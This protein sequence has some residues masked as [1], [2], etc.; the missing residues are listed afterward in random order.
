MD[1][2][3][4]LRDR[5]TAGT[6]RRP[7]VRLPA[8]LAQPSVLYPLL[9]VLAWIA[10]LAIARAVGV[11]LYNRDPLIRIGA[12]PVVGQ[13]DVRLSALVLPA[14][15]V[16]AFAVAY[17][18]VPA[19]RL[20]FRWLLAG[21]WLA[22]AGWAVS[23]ALVDGP[24]ALPA[25]LQ[26]RYEY[27]N[28]VPLVTS[29][30]DFLATFTDRIDGYSTHT[31]GHPPLMVLVFWAM[32]RIGL[33]G[34]I[35]ATVLVIG[36][37]AVAAPAVLVAAR[38]VAGEAQA[39]R[40]APFVVFAPL[41]VWVATSADALFM[42]VA[43]T[44]VAMFAVATGR[45]GRGALLLAAG[46]GVVLGLGLHLTY[47]LA[48]L[49]ALVLAIAVVRRRPGP[50]VA[51]SAGVLAVAL[52]FVANGFW[53][54]DGLFATHDQYAEGVASRRPYLEFL[55]ISFGAFALAVGPAAFAGVAA[56]R[57]RR[58]WILVGGG[59]VAVAASGLS[60]LSRGETERIWLPFMPW[61]LL[62]AAAL[63]VTRGAS[64]A[65]VGLQ[66]A[67]AIAVQVGIHTP[68]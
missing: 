55:A 44:G 48:P 56:L 31:R 35:P 22:A 2:A 64:R 36:A 13:L 60:G 50:L 49:G 27:L 20:P 42:G 39:R 14:L 17:A 54:L 43:A 6:D 65:W 12:P 16:A 45:Q 40:A 52:A 26:T 5:P 47:G 58:L 28:D 67:V 37:G 68:W 9:G 41:A 8:T 29:P 34:G 18:P 15:A 38:E 23:L 7:G 1:R 59:L 61:V 25:P 57:D 62:A 19:Q 32:S 53:W 51:A 46:A 21:A 24:E 63:G 30:G 3:T 11:D 33:G 66:V 10:L 4:S